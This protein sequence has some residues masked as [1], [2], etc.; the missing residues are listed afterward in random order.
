[1]CIGYPTFD[2]EM[3]NGQ[4]LS[5]EISWNNVKNMISYV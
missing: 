4:N 3:G 5:N 2:K 1:M